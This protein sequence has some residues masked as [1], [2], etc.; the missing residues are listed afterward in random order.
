MNATFEVSLTIK[1][2]ELEGKKPPR[3]TAQRGDSMK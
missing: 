1:G 2:V 3:R